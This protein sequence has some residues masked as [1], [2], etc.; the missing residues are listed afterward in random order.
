[1]RRVVT[2][3]LAEPP[4]PSLVS[5]G[6]FT[7]R[8][9]VLMIEDGK[10]HPT[11]IYR[12]ACRVGAIVPASVLN[13]SLTGNAITMDCTTTVDGRPANKTRGFL[14]PDLGWYFRSPLRL[15][16]S[17]LAAALF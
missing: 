1:M 15:R 7:S 14:L 16:S 2:E 3:F 12:T 6:A 8:Q 13:M 5:G 17:D 11:L 4:I 9:E 10:L